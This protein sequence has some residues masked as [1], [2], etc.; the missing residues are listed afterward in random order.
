MFS[1][2]HLSIR[3]FVR[4][5]VHSSPCHRVKVFVLKFIGPHILKTL[6]MDF[7][8]IWHDDRLAYQH[9]PHPGGDLGVKVTEFS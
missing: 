1:L 6:L 4:T 7:I 3:S 9:Y 5:F 2:F 8:H